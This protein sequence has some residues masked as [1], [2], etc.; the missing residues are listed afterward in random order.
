ML[1]LFSGMGFRPQVNVEETLIKF[2]QGLTNN[3]TFIEHIENIEEFLDR[4]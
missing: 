3:K 4:K 2:K 1:C